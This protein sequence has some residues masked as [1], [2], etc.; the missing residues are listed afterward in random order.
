MRPLRYFQPHEFECKKHCGKCLGLMDETLL[1]ML[2]E[3]RHR[4]KRPLG[5]NSGYRCEAKNASTPGAVKGS[6]HMKGLAVDLA[7]TDSE[8][9]CS[10]V[11]EAFGLGFRRIGVAETFVHLDIDPDK[12]QDILFLY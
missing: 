8:L 5:V 9:R 6:S 7:C 2:D 12:P 11:K 3:L 4:V 10:I 1:V